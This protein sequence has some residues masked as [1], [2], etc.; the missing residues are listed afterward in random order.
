MA[1]PT[2]LTTLLKRIST[3]AEEV[4]DMLVVLG[5]YNKTNL[6]AQ[7]V[8]RAAQ[9]VAIKLYLRS[10]N[11]QG[12]VFWVDGVAGSNANDGLSFAA[13]KL[14]FKAA[15][16]L[17]TSNKNDHIFVLDYWQPAGEDWPIVVDKNMV[18][19]IGIGG[20]THPYPSIHPA[21]DKAAFQLTSSGQYGELANFTIGGGNSHGGIEMGNEGQVD[22]F[23][24][25]DC[26]FGHQ[27]F[28][29]PLNGILDPASGTRGGY[30]CRI[31]RCTFM[32]DLA[33]CKG[34]ITGNAI[35]L[36]P[37][38]DAM[39]WRDLRIVDCLFKGTAIGINLMRAFDAEI[40]NNKFVCADAAHGEAITLQ[41][42][43]RGCMVD[44]N[45]AM[46]GG[47]AVMTNEPYRDLATGANNHWGVNWTTNAV[48]LPRQT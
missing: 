2:D 39:A 32:G 12:D 8:L 33:N 9:E 42:A 34:K 6:D 3:P 28:G 11:I 17:C 21:I 4:R 5:D 31:E 14:T 30:G 13:P 40:L 19:I 15:L 22:G 10:L 7:D 41:S 44:G 45:V 25:R 47:D 46:N 26:I 43:C 24:I 18:H 23:H 48:D 29:T 38:T 36:L 1:W 16:A 20:Q 35:D 37:N 27:W